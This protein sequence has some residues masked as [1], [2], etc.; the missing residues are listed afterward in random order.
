M[1]VEGAHPS[2]AVFRSEFSNWVA[3]PSGVVFPLGGGSSSAT[4]DFNESGGD[5]DDR[6]D[7][8]EIVQKNMETIRSEIRAR[9]ESDLKLGQTII[10]GFA[11]VLVLNSQINIKRFLPELPILGLLLLLIWQRSEF[12]LFRLGIRLMILKPKT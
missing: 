3:P 8:I 7:M 9:I 4:P 1:P 6:K 2:H 12:S 10:A 11:A 5:L